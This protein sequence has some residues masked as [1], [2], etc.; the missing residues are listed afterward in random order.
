M[1]ETNKPIELS[2]ADGSIK[3]L[4][5]SGPATTIIYYEGTYFKCYSEEVK[6]IVYKEV[7][8]THLRDRENG[9]PVE[10]YIP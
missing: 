3:K 10:A 6:K 8:C 1:R 4:H 5:Y 7:P 2:F 9:T